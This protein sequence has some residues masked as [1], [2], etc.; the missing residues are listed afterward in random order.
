[1]NR[2]IRELQRRIAELE[3]KLKNDRCAHGQ[4]INN[5]RS[6]QNRLLE[7]QR[8][9]LQ[10]E[11]FNLRQELNNIIEQEMD[12]LKNEQ[13]ES[14][15]RIKHDYNS[16][17]NYAESLKQEH[18]RKVQEITNQIEELRSML[19]KSHDME[20]VAALQEL[21]ILKNIYKHIE[22]LPHD[23]FTP[24][25]L[26]IY[27]GEQNNVQ[28]LIDQEMYQAAIAAAISACAGLG[29]IENDI[30]IGMKEWNE[31]FIEYQKEL[32]MIENLVKSKLLRCSPAEND[33]ELD[34]LYDDDL[35]NFWSEGTFNDVLGEMKIYQKR[36]EDINKD[37]VAEYV[38]INKDFTVK[39]MKSDIESMMILD[40][41]IHSI[42]D[43][44]KSALSASIQRENFLNSLSTVLYED[45]CV[46][47]ED[48]GFDK[49]DVVDLGIKKANEMH[50][51]IEAVSNEDQR[52]TIHLYSSHY[53][54]HYHIMIIPVKH[55]NRVHND[56]YIYINNIVRSNEIG[57]KAEQL[58]IED[59]IINLSQ[60]KNIFFEHIHYLNSEN[61]M[62]DINRRSKSKFKLDISEAQ[63]RQIINQI[64]AE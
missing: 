7:E 9:T 50:S 43:Y 52:E 35:L 21:D 31:Y 15:R 45:Q 20:R 28:Q 57:E 63:R 12:R 58:D 37:G 34:L 11:I 61:M 23:F 56:I 29:K 32:K 14:I 41:K 3:R 10:T 16:L 39:T 60:K 30:R 5:L 49:S 42:T 64:K 51:E 13:K 59:I 26:V 46:C 48:F 36:V 17:K 38:K 27:K 24:G 25:G 55:E 47:E 8:Q 62:I 54:A 44:A 6:Q 1:M 53:D 4:E 2:R 22:A 40:Y 33:N 19:E 18:Y